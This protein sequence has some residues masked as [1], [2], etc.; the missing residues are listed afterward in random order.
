MTEFAARVEKDS[1]SNAGRRLISMVVT[2]PRIIHS[3]VMTHRAFAR[4]AS[5]SRAIPFSKMVDQV[6]TSPFVPIKWGAEQRGMQTGDSLSEMA[7]IKC[8]TAWLR[9]RDHAVWMAKEMHSQG[10]HKSICNRVLEP[11]SWITVVITATEWCNFF[12]LRCHPDAE[13]HLQKI[14]GMM[15]DA[16]KKSSP[17]FVPFGEWHLPF[18]DQADLDTPGITEDD[19]SAIS[20]ARSARVS[21]LTHDGLRDHSKDQELFHKLVTGSGFGHYSPHE[22]VATPLENPYEASGPFR[23]WR[24]FRKNFVLENAE[25]PI[26]YSP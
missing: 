2:Y 7:E 11:Y 12:R 23:G 25:T 16:I 21:Y 3:E 20:T 4:N 10:L 22:H 1:I 24:Q 13:I 14:A 5:S 26:K 15:R 8:E 19:L 9:A 6:I 17:E 18:I